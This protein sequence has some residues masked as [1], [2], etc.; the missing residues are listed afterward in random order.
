MPGPGSLACPK[1]ESRKRQKARETREARKVVTA[2]RA[3]CVE[4]D[5]HCRLAGVLAAGPCFG[6]SEW[7]HLAEY[8]RSKTLGQPAEQ[9]HT[10]QGSLMLCQGHHGRYDR[11]EFEL[12]P[13]TALGAES[14][15]RIRM[16]GVSVLSV[17]GCLK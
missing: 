13:L 10:V 2:V 8:R 7:A 3:Q 15:L 1:P 12:E 16:N 9:R 11:H 14:T 6:R 5:G 4:R 17:P